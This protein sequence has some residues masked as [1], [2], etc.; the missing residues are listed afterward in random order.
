MAAKRKSP[1]TPVT[2]EN[3]LKTLQALGFKVTPPT[4]E[5]DRVKQEASL[6]KLGFSDKAKKAEKPKAPSEDLVGHL[7]IVHCV[8]GVT[9]G[10]GEIR[11]PREQASLFN[12]L[13]HQDKLAKD[14]YFD[15]AD[16]HS[17]SRCYMIKPGNGRDQHHKYQKLP[18]S[19]AQFDGEAMWEQAA[20]TAGKIDLAGYNPQALPETRSF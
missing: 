4:N 11:L 18:L 9:Y 19:Q 20:I 17:V 12:A 8:S 14:A 15:T 13:L 16:Y 3:A 10:P 1:S 7:G 2:L 6:E 5:E